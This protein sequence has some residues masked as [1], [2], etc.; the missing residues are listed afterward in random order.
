M[1]N[2]IGQFTGDK[3]VKID[4]EW[5]RGKCEDCSKP[6]KG[7]YA[8]KCHDCFWALKRNPTVIAGK[9]VPHYGKAH[10]WIAKVKGKPKKCENCDFSSEN[11]RQ[12]HW[13]NIS[14]N[15]LLEETDWMRL[16]V[17]CH[18]IFDIGKNS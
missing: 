14:D 8:K 4:G 10:Y 6:V 11:G 2:A 18:R 17:S 5:Y 16:C 9:K 1:R 12:F 15:Y 7:I 13:A 3:Y